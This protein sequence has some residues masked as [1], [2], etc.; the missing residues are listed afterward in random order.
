MTPIAQVPSVES[1]DTGFLVDSFTST[2][3]EFFR[4]LQL[5]YGRTRTQEV[6]VN[7]T[8]QEEAT[9]DEEWLVTYDPLSDLTTRREEEIIEEEEIYV[10][11]KIMFGDQ[12]IPRT[13]H[14]IR[15]THQIRSAI[16][17]EK[18]PRTFTIPLPEE[19]ED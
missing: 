12:P 9:Q 6:Q 5:L 7:A 15:M 19:L 11:P 17:P 1:I 14:P 3:P 13:R 18:L 8:A 4:I 2:D 16:P 10:H